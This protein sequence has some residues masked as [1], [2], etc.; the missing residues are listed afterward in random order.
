MPIANRY[1]SLIFV[2]QRYP[3]YICKLNL[4]AAMDKEDCRNTLNPQFGQSSASRLSFSFLHESLSKIPL[5]NAS[6]GQ[7]RWQGMSQP[8]HPHVNVYVN[9]VK[10]D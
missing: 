8:L 1:F 6:L 9:F 3:L 2:H 7:A 5:R 10:A 4:Q